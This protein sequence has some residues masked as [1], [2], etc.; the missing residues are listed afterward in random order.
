MKRLF[1]ALSLALLVSLVVGAGVALARATTET[2]VQEFEISGARDNPC[3]GQSVMFDGT[4]R[5]VFH[6]T[7]DA[8][9]NHHV[10]FRAITQGSGVDPVTG[11]KFLYRDVGGVQ[12]FTAQDGT[13]TEL[14]SVATFDV[15]S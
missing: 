11:E 2:F 5:F 14:T 15:I 12:E 6:V 9:G 13:P 1:A 7:E 3:T 4:Q 8:A 10:G